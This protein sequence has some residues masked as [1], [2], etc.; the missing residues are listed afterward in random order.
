[1]LTPVNNAEDLNNLAAL[2]YEKCKR[3]GSAQ[4]AEQFKVL[5]SYCLI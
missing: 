1:M 5:L 2:F 3:Q 4:V